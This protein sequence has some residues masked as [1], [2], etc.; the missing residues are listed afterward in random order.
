MQFKKIQLFKYKKHKIKDNPFPRAALYLRL[1]LG[2]SQLFQLIQWN[3]PGNREDG[4]KREIPTIS[5]SLHG[6]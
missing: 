3:L 6:L 1:V 2:R 4:E 5:S